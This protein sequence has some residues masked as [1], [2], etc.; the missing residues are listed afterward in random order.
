MQEYQHHIL[1]PPQFQYLLSLTRYHENASMLKL[2]TFTSCNK[3]SRRSTIPI[4]A[5]SR[6]IS[7]LKYRIR[8]FDYS[9]SL[10]LQITMDR[11]DSNAT[12]FPQKSR[13]LSLSRGPSKAVPFD[14]RLLRKYAWI[15]RIG[16]RCPP[17]KSG[18]WAEITS[19]LR[20]F[21]SRK[22]RDTI[23]EPIVTGRSRV[24]C[25]TVGPGTTNN[26]YYH[27]SGVCRHVEN[28]LDTVPGW[29]W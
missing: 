17:S 26:R 18:R 25:V 3:S 1:F 20:A 12:P 8:L 23:R 24:W 14:R 15:P 11:L 22:R 13:F 16:E 29:G 5:S 27:K 7:I 6:K 19:D 28:W 10:S 4:F 9:L 21:W 2:T